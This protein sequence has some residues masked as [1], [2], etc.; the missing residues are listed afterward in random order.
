MSSGTCGM[1]SGMHRMGTGT[2]GMGS[3]TCGMRVRKHGISSGTCGMNVRTC[4]MVFLGE[5]YIFEEI[6]YSKVR[7]HLRNN[8][9]KRKCLRSWVR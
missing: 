9:L 1:G 3:G 2:Y 7:R 6:I 5:F 8:V 4:G